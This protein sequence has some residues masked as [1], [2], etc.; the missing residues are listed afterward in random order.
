MVG[1]DIN[2]GERLQWVVDGG[3]YKASCLLEDVDGG[4]GSDGL[5]ISEVPIFFNYLWLKPSNE[6]LR[7]S[8][9]GLNSLTTIF[10]KRMILRSWCRRGRRK[11]C[12]G[13]Y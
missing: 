3:K 12:N 10:C 2:A 13:F 8:F 9:R 7:L 1:H 5:L 11:T 6:V 4:D